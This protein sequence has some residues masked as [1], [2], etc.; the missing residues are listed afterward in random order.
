[1]M[2]GPQTQGFSYSGN[3]SI[4]TLGAYMR[5]KSLLIATSALATAVLIFGCSASSPPPAAKAPFQTVLTTKQLMDWVLDPQA[6][7]VWASVATIVTEA[8][9]EEIAPKTDEEWAAIRNAAATV[10]EAGN[11][12]MLDERAVNQDDWMQ[13]TKTMIDAAKVVLTAIE[14]KDAPA[15]F[16]AGSDMY[17]ACSGCHA[18][19]IFGGEE[20]A[21]PAK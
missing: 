16:T 9:T 17:L 1:M 5:F 19:Y 3:N 21:Q 7:I 11:L 4:P 14:A 10:A 20:E 18:A 15:V 13:K 8:G 6:D 2:R 12:L